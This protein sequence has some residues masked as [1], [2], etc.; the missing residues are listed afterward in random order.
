MVV[1]LVTVAIGARYELSLERMRQTAAIA[2]FNRTLLW[3]KDDFLADP[4]VQRHLEPLEKM[5][6]G[7]KKRKKHHPFDRPY[8]G[9]FKSFALHRALEQSREGDYV[10]WADASKYHD[11]R[12]R[13]VSIHEAIEGLRGDRRPP[14]PTQPRAVSAA[15]AQSRWYAGVT[16]IPRRTARSAY[17]VLHCHVGNCDQQLFLPNRYRASV[18]MRTIA[19][20]PEHV[21][22]VT[23]MA[24]RPHV[25]NANILL[26][27]NAFN[28]RLMRS[29]I[30]MATSKPDT[31]CASS[32]QEQG[33][34]S[35]LTMSARVP[36]VNACPYMRLEGFNKCQ[37]V[38]K[39]SRWFLETLS[40]GAFEIITPSEIED[41][42]RQAFS[43][44]H[45]LPFVGPGRPPSTACASTLV[46]C[47][48]RAS[49]RHSSRAV[50]ARSECR[51]QRAWPPG[52]G[53]RVY[54]SCEDV[55]RPTPAREHDSNAATTLANPHRGAQSSALL[56]A[57]RLHCC[58]LS[59][60]E[61]GSRHPQPRR[62]GPAE[63]VWR[64]QIRLLPLGAVLDAALRARPLRVCQRGARKHDALRGAPRKRVGRALI[65]NKKT[66]PQPQLSCELLAEMEKAVR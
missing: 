5:E 31:F 6:R 12:Y 39:S 4:L 26:E 37:D 40:S 9:A 55:L 3:K 42:V 15:Y 10:L 32:T 21:S 29:W 41:E 56:T 60:C 18:N 34:F 58:E 47:A 24:R 20:Y 53:E 25:M 63:G 11:A 50:L 45:R 64:S 7:H 19:G 44:C 52:H 33:V 35:I 66:S 30:K 17:G 2:G 65:N 27:N 57:L 59:L 36:M 14:R 1:T 62:D 54:V 28:R 13:D 51:R 61:V 23:A 16:R 49:L 48:A 38:T 43:T 8:C 22:N 46:I